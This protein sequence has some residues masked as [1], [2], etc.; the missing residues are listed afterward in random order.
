MYLLFNDKLCY[1]DILKDVKKI[2]ANSQPVNNIL[3]SLIHKIST[4]QMKN[5][6]LIRSRKN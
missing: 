6:S 5:I 4:E 1:I 2:F 3:I